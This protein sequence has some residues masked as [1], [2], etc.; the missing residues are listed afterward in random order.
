MQIAHMFYVLLLKTFITQKPN[1]DSFLMAKICLNDEELKFGNSLSVVFC[2]IYQEK[3]NWVL[4]RIP[5]KC[6]HG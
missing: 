6:G 3:Y 2:Q 4:L 1:K 5:L